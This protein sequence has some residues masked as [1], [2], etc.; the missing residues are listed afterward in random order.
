M[1][2]FLDKQEDYDLPFVR[3]DES[4]SQLAQQGTTGALSGKTSSSF[5]GQRPKPGLCMSQISGVRKSTLTHTN[6]L[7]KL[8]KFGIETVHEPELAKLFNDVNKWGLDIFKV[9]EY[10]NNHPL[11]ATLY[12]IFRVN[13]VPVLAIHIYFC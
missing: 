9:A 4:A 2:T 8:P 1:M 6:S 3:T 12:T 13:L 7:T 5:T 10:S 11:T